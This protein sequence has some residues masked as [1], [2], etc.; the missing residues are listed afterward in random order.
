MAQNHIEFENPY[1]VTKP[2]YL[3]G[4]SNS[5]THHCVQRLFEAQVERSPDDIAVR[6]EEGG[7]SYR[8]LNRRANQLAHHFRALGVGPETLVGICLKRSIDLVVGLLGI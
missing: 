8:E 4:T 1:L 2:W 7:S 5:L 6:S 3:C